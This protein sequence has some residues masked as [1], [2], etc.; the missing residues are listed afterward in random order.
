MDKMSDP[1][2]VKKFYRKAI[3]M[4]HPDKINSGEFNPEKMYI[5][6]QCFAALTEAYNEYMKEGA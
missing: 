2:Q 3:M 6:N 5:A 4:C 1:A